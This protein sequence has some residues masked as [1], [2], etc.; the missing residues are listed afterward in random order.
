MTWTFLKYRLLGLEPSFL[1]CKE[2]KKFR[3][4]ILGRVFLLSLSAF[5]FKHLMAK[6]A[7]RCS[8]APP[9]MHT[10][11]S[12]WHLIQALNW[13]NFPVSL[14]YWVLLWSYAVLEWHI[15]AYWFLYENNL[16]SWMNILYNTIYFRFLVEVFLSVLLIV[17][18]E[19][20]SDAF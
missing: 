2:P 4:T 13:S 17:V 5:W 1:I 14:G 3:L 9:H 11:T 19:D 18:Q 7:R 15:S 8:Y 12:L 16:F 6:A 20:T 10:C